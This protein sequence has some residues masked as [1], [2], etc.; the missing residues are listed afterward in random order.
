[1]IVSS[2]GQVPSVPVFPKKL[3]MS[4]LS[5]VIGSLVGI[6]GA[7]TAYYMDHTVKTPEDI[8]PDLPLP[9]PNLHCGPDPDHT[10]RRLESNFWEQLTDQNP[11]PI[12]LGVEPYF[13]NRGGRYPSG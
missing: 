11:F 12:V 10:R 7:F 9:G 4:F 2:W 1:M 13:P 3:L 5:L 6:A 8:Q